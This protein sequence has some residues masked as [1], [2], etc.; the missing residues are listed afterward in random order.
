[1]TQLKIT[2][3][4]LLV[5]LSALAAGAL[6]GYAHLYLFPSELNP[7]LVTQP[8]LIDRGFILYR[9]LGDQKPPLLLLLV[10]W[11]MPLFQGDPVTAAR[12]LHFSVIVL[13]VFLAISWVYWKA[14]LWAA[15][16]SGLFMLTWSQFLGLWATAYYDLITSL[17]FLLFFLL[18]TWSNPGK[19][20][21]KALIGGLL[22]GIAVLIKQQAIMLAFIFMIG[23]AVEL[24]TQ[25]LPPRK[26]AFLLA[27]FLGSFLAPIL[28]FLI[29]SQFRS[30]TLNETVFW[31]FTLLLQNSFSSL[32]T[33]VIPPGQFFRTLQIFI[34]LI[35]FTAS[36]FIPDFGSGVT[37]NIRIWLLV[38][39]VA[40]VFFQYPRYSSRHWAVVF[41]F[42]AIIS[43][44]ACADIIAL[45]KHRGVYLVL[46]VFLV[47][48][49]WWIYRA[50]IQ[51]LSAINHPQI[52]IGEYTDLFPLAEE[53]ESKIPLSGSIA[54][55]PTDEANANLHYILQRDPPHYFIYHYPWFMNNS[56]IKDNW[57]AALES[58]QTPVI[59]NFPQTWDVNIY[60]PELISYITNNYMVIDT[61]EWKG[62]SI[63]IMQRNPINTR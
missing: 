29:A 44:V 10:T 7:N 53:L 14:G 61:V 17:F 18:M 8:Y 30:N 24:L 12:T 56:S 42:A 28:V 38:F 3:L 37:R 50:A 41:P 55:F 13:L 15:F 48:P 4:D 63:Q 21:L 2:R 58:E 34:L 39:L 27:V 33:L 54:I 36:L 40:A 60:A 57:I 20:T 1:L 31:N 52:V 47:A 5:M 51:Y 23:L 25:L 26:S 6:I 22:V 11:L 32:G 46:V 49:A 19:Q 9:D 35:P 59:L 45:I 16:F 62:Q 43:G